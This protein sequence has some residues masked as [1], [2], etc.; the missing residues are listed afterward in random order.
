MDEQQR[1]PARTTSAGVVVK[2]ALRTFSA[3]GA[4]FLGAAVAFYALLSAAPLFVLVLR[5]VGAVFGPERAES[6]LWSGLSAW[7]APEGLAALRELTERMAHVEASSGAMGAV[8]VVYGSTRLFRAL[9]RALN[10]L[11]GIDLEAIER[12]RPRVQRYAR[13]YGLALALALFVALIVAVLVVIKAAFALLALGASGLPGSAV[14][15]RLLWMADLFVSI[16][17]A[18]ALFFSLFRFLPE[19]KVAAG[20]AALSAAVSTFLFALGSTLVTLYVGHKHVGDLYDGAA[21][22]VVALLW[23]Y[24]SAQVFFLGA[25]VGAAY[26]GRGVDPA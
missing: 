16:V 8:L 7:M 14:L 12:D 25:C 24:Y 23:V 6:A 15:T 10:Q 19:A 21:A 4:R 20:E 22:L 11:W 2:Q 9:R 17:L 3:R 18:F 1:A 26:H 13:R 5:L